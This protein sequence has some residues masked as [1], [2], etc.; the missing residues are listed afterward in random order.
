MILLNDWSGDRG[1]FSLPEDVPVYVCGQNPLKM[2]P[3]FDDS[4]AESAQRSARG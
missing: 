4:L 3:D 2:Q 1:R